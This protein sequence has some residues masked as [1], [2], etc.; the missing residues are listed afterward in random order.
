MNFTPEFLSVLFPIISTWNIVF[1]P[2]ALF[3]VFND[4]FTGW[5]RLSR[6]GFAFS[7]VGMLADSVMLLSG[8]NTSVNPYWA[9]KDLGLGII[10]LGF[11]IEIRRSRKGGRT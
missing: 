8:M 3:L 1:A 7:C 6:L 10:C 5:P 9:F 2:L 11:L 4:K